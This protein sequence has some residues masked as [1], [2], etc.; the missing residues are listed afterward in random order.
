MFAYS[1]LA[2]ALTLHAADAAGT[3]GI[4]LLKNAH[5]A[6]RLFRRGLLPRQASGTSLSSLFPGY[7][8]YSKLGFQGYY[9]NSKWS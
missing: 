9:L 7:D 3:F 2:I 1:L 5:P 4:P 6:E 8:F